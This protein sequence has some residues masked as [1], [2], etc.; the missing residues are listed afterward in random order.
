MDPCGLAARSD[1]PVVPETTVR[2][3]ESDEVVPK[4]LL[5]SQW[6]V[7]PDQ[8]RRAEGAEMVEDC[9]PTAADTGLTP[10]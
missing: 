4:M 2:G 3:A 7:V 5:T 9:P 6:K 1:P 10:L 8:A